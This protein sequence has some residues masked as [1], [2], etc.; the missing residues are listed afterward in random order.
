[1]IDA[2]G[3]GVDRIRLATPGLVANITPAIVGDVPVRRSMESASELMFTVSDP[4]GRVMRSRLVTEASRISVDGLRFALVKPT[5]QGPDTGLTF[6]DELT[7]LLRQKKGPKKA[8]RDEVTRAQFARSLVK[9]AAPNAR[10]VCPEL[11]K[12]Q[13]I[14]DGKEPGRTVTSSRVDRDRAPGIPRNATGLTV[15]GAA[16]TSTQIKVADELIRECLKYNPPRKAVYAAIQAAIVE[17]VMGTRGMVTAVDHDSIGIFQ[18]RQ[19]YH[20]YKNLRSIAYNVRI[21]MTK[22]FTSHP[23][24]GAIS[25]AQKNPGWSS[26]T[27]AA[28]NCGP[29]KQYEHR[30]DEHRKEAEKWL[31]AFMGGD[32]GDT[33]R[34]VTTTKRYPF[35]VGK[36]EDY[37]TALK[38]LADEVNWR[39][40]VVGNTFYFIAEPTLLR[41]RR[42]MLI[43]ANTRGVD[44]VDWELDSGKRASQATITGRIGGWRAPPGSVVVLGPVHGPAQGRWLVASIEGTLNKPDVMITLKRPSRP[45]PEP[46]SETSS[47]T[48]GGRRRGSSGGAGAD[49]AVRWVK[50]QVGVKQG[51]SKYRSW[52]NALGR[53]DEAWC[54]NF[55]AYVM[56]EVCGFQNIPSNF[57]ASNCWLTWSQADAVS[58]KNLQPGDIICYGGSRSWTLHVNMYVGNGKCVGGNQSNAVTEWTLAYGKGA[59]SG[60]IIGIVRPKYR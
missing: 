15:K 50:A 35:E 10:F 29:A 8:F 31:E 2:L 49:K 27:I 53:G 25:M 13:P 5:R 33:S 55:I 21:F 17:S 40:F 39:A 11:N 44:R 57:P 16:A 58:E 42:R 26:G 4:E 51:D 41:S 22:S 6:E 45:K 48:S 12:V 28:K 30:Y 34:T 14:E 9:E 23:D 19:M 7:Y 37:W 54:S 47:R 32:V 3:S 1:M 18:G 59:Y 24:G 60:G 20:S 38:R 46:A 43:G 36:D 56:K 52:M